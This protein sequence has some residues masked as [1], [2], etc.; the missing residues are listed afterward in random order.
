VIPETSQFERDVMTLEEL[1]Q[2]L[3]PGLTVARERARLDTLPVPRI[4]GTGRRYL[5]SRR[6]YEELLSMQHAQK[7]PT[8]LP[9]VGVDRAA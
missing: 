5:Y 2:R 1:S 6:A 7:H 3:G 4:P 9:P 8:K